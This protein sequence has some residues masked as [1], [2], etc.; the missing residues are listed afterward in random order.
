MPRARKTAG[1]AVGG[2]VTAGGGTTPASVGG[3]DRRRRRA[4]RTDSGSGSQPASRPSSTTGGATLARASRSLR[5]AVLDGAVAGQVHD[6][7]GV[8]HDALEPVLGHHHGDA[9]VVHE[10]RD[11]GEHLLGAGRVERRRGLVEH[12]DLAGAR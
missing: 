4:S 12:E 1:R 8:L 9:E 2:R 11:R 6:A 3:S 5:V 10:P 7:V